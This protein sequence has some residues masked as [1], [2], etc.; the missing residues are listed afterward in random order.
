M[1]SVGITGFTIAI[2]PRTFQISS[3]QYISYEAETGDKHS[4]EPS[5]AASSMV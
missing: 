3:A 2:K 4:V 1:F 5:S